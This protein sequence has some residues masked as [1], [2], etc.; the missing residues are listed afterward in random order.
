MLWQDRVRPTVEDVLQTRGVSGAVFAVSRDFGAPEY[1]VVGVDADQQLL[2]ADTL[3]PV[4][5]VTKLATALAVLRLVA[6]GTW[7]LDDPIGQYVPEAVIAADGV[8]LRM[9]LCH[10]SGLT[11]DISEQQVPYNAELDWPKL[12]RGCL[13]TPLTTPPQKQVR[14]SNLGSGVLAAIVERVTGQP[15]KVALKELVLEPL[16]LEA[17]LG[18][19]PPRRPAK[20]K[21]DFGRHAGTD[22]EPY[23]TPFW[24]ALALPWSGL[25]TTAAG[26]LGLVGAF[27]G[28]APNFLPPTLLAEAA[29]NQTRDLSGGFFV[30]LM[31]TPCPWGLGIELR[32]N[33]HPHW[34][35]ADLSPQTFG[36]AGASGCQTWFDPA[37]GISFAMLGTRNFERWWQKWPAIV[38]VLMAAVR[39]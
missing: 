10:T 12:A 31:W 7:A 34:T 13:A 3:F 5:S 19:E 32:G 1:L 22:L 23:N 36:H 39:A 21:G 4:A 2:A 17:F 11:L 30:P 28:N 8:T 38:S 18:V 29:R 26:A 27:A 20:I 9:L 15:F 37:S 6:A 14:Y 16:Q 25:I 35:S 24:R 33:K